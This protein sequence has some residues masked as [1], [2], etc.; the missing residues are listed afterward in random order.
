MEFTYKSQ[1][2]IATMTDEE[3]EDY[4]LKKRK[5]EEALIE[6]KAK[7]EAEKLLKESK[8]EYQAKAKVLED[9]ID[10]LSADIKKAS[11]TQKKKEVDETLENVLKATFED[12]SNKEI[13]EKAKTNMTMGES[14]NLALKADPVW[15][16]DFDGDSYG[17]L[18]TD[19]QR[20]IVPLLSD[21]LNLR[22]I[23]SSSP[24]SKSTIWYPQVDEIE[25]GV[26]A[27]QY[28]K[29]EEGKVTPKP[30]VKP[31][32]KGAQASVRWLAGIADMP[33]EILDDVS[34]MLPFISEMLYQSLLD[35]EDYN[36]LRGT[37]T[38][39]ELTGIETV[40]ED[41]DG[42][43]V[44]PIDRIIDAAIGQVGGNKGRASHVFLNNRDAVKIALNKADG[45]GE[46]DLPGS[47]GFVNGNLTIGGLAVVPNSNIDANEFIT[48]DRRASHIFRR[49]A[50]NL[51]MSFENKD[52]FETNM[53]TFRLEERI[54]L[55]HVRPNWWV[56][57]ELVES[58]EG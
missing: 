11:Q 46:Y 48:G 13:V 36:I 50:A 15:F 4:A 57:G 22:N 39:P 28:E 35:A 5:H 10:R 23:L 33:V 32:F 37:G 24:T 19:F 20:G 6:K 34:E 53:V 31:K 45:S 18:T 12:E 8:K 42:D 7:E 27:W 29:D 14:Y 40:A 26:E 3:R 30:T 56:K 16:D 38:A 2:E 49:M 9:R 25:G 1:A 47:V 43:M 54:A 17:N 51:K 52:N 58:T 41:Y 21:N 55:A 44:V